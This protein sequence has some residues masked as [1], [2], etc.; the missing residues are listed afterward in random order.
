MS[1][2]ASVSYPV[3]QNEEILPSTPFSGSSTD[4]YYTE[5]V[6]Y[7]PDIFP[8]VADWIAAGGTVSLRLTALVEIDGSLPSKVMC[9]YTTATIG[10]DGTFSGDNFLPLGAIN[11]PG[12]TRSLVQSQWAQIPPVPGQIIKVGCAWAA[13]DDASYIS[14]PY[15]VVEVQFGGLQ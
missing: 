3:L 13:G 15:C 6:G 8:S 4:I 9:S 7:A 5:P 11:F 2:P 12:G 14:V 10:G 1:L